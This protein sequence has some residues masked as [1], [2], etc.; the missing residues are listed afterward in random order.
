MSTGVASRGAGALRGF[1]RRLLMV[2]A[3][4]VFGL[5]GAPTF[6]SVTISGQF[7]PLSIQRGDRSRMRI[8]FQ[9]NDT[10]N[11]SPA[12]EFFQPLA[13]TTGSI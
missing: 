8:N 9:G 10:V 5:A 13:G 12:G 1:A 6:A 11:P 4:L 7:T 3:G 2:G